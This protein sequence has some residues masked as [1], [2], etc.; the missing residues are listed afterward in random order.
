MLD[1]LGFDDGFDIP[2]SPDGVQSMIDNG[3]SPK[4]VGSLVS[5]TSTTPSGTVYNVSG[6][7][8]TGLKLNV[9]ASDQ[10][11]E[12]GDNTSGGSNGGSSTS[13]APGATSSS[14]STAASTLRQNCV[15]S[16]GYAQA[17]LALLTLATVRSL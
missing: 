11:N 7:T 3:I 16:S 4:P 14:K 12:P 2:S 1:S 8:V 15:A 17:V 13:G 5:L 9:L 10:S 6:E